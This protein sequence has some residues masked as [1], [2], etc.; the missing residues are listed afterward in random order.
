[1]SLLKMIQVNE[2]SGSEAEK[3]PHTTTTTTDAEK[4]TKETTTTTT[5]G[6]QINKQRWEDK[7]HTQTHSRLERLWRREWSISF[8]PHST[9]SRVKRELFQSP[10]R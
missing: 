1:M 4:T 5:I 6:P 9:R 8:F 3:K 2:C 7:L 10:I